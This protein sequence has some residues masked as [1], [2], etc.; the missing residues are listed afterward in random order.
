MV[1]GV[2]D[3]GRALAEAVD[4]LEAGIVVG[5]VGAAVLA[6]AERPGGGD[7]LASVDVRGGIVG[8]GGAVVAGIGDLPAVSASS[9]RITWPSM[10]VVKVKGRPLIGRLARRISPGRGRRGRRSGSASRPEA[11]SAA[12]SFC[13]RQKGECGVPPRR[14]HRVA[15]IPAPNLS[16]SAIQRQNQ[17]VRP[18]RQRE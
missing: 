10:S 13:G 14:R 9:R 6:E 17:S 15:D 3:S 2:A 5:D 1:H 4:R 8:V 11:G 18:A 12:G 16:L 7:D